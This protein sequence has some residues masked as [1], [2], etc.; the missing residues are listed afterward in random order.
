MTKQFSLHCSN[1]FYEFDSHTTANIQTKYDKYWI[2]L[3][4]K[5]NNMYEAIEHWIEYNKN[6]NK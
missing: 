4:T 5:I 2:I 6:K 3:I 1:G